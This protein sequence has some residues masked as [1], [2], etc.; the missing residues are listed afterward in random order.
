MGIIGFADID[1]AAL[2]RDDER[3]AAEF[4]ARRGQ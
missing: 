3:I 2:E 4:D 1:T